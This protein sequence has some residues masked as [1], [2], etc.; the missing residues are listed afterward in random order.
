[1]DTE[2]MYRR[3]I[4]DAEVGEPHPFY[5]QHYYQYRRAYDRARRQR[6]LPGGFYD[7]RRRRR[8]RLTIVVLILAA[9]VGG[10]W[11]SRG[12]IQPLAV[13]NN[14][15]EQSS[16]P[17]ATAT[18]TR[19][20]I[21][22]TPTLLPTPSLLTLQIGGNARIVNT[23]GAA[24]RSRKQPTLS[25]P[26]TASFKEGEVVRILEGPVEADGFIWWKIEGKAGTGWSAQQSKDGTVWIQPS[27]A[28]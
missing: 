9:V 13:A 20:P 26:T 23:V 10:Y 12:R 6:G 17:A 15:A 27:A 18:P 25:A 8:T 2:E 22:P 7:I 4:A 5:Y 11:F 28:I 21:F 16:I 19:T 3:G 24:L 1:M 14:A